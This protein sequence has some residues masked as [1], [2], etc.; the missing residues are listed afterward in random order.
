MHT[1]SA[2]GWTLPDHISALLTRMSQSFNSTLIVENG[3]RLARKPTA[4]A[5]GK[6][7]LL[8]AWHHLAS[9]P[10]YLPEYGRKHVA[11][12]PS[13][14]AQGLLSDEFCD[15]PNA[16]SATCVQDLDR[17]L[18]TPAPFPTHSIGVS[19]EGVLRTTRLIQSEGNWEAIESSWRSL[20]PQPGWLL[21]NTT[22]PGGGWMVLRN[23]A[24][25]CLCLRVKLK[26][27]DGV[28]VLHQLFAD[29]SALECISITELGPWKVLPLACMPPCD[30]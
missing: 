2:H 15:L 9:A 30:P 14:S 28:T 12:E 5:S 20:L 23:T 8:T 22:H 1:L 6:S 24:Y 19:R 27:K 11:F 26:S 3:F 18:E 7:S 16:V 21:H 13:E 29:E 17:I 4:Q 10:D 25:G